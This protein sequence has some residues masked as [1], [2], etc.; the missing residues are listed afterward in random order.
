MTPIAARLPVGF[1]ISQTFQS[2][3]DVLYM[4]L[5]SARYFLNFGRGDRPSFALSN[6]K[7]EN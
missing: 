4:D 1:L 3:K 6:F 2:G 5:Q 7:V